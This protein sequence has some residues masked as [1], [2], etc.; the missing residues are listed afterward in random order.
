MRPSALPYVGILSSSKSPFR[1]PNL[2]V[3]PYTGS[4][5]LCT[6]SLT[7]SV[8]TSKDGASTQSKLGVS[9]V[10][11]PGNRVPTTIIEDS[12]A[13]STQPYHNPSKSSSKKKVHYSS[14]SN[15]RIERHGHRS[16]RDYGYDSSRRSSPARMS[17]LLE[18]ERD[19]E[20]YNLR[21]VR[22]ALD[23]A[24]GT[25]KQLTASFDHL[26]GLPAESNKEN[27]RLKRERN[28]ISNKLND[29]MEDLDHEKRLNRVLQQESSGSNTTERPSSR[30]A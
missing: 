22:E 6:R 19:D 11:I 9:S 15:S 4:N 12:K 10:S 27:R 28:D 5:K 17:D 26:N 23:A 30:P 14:S 24:N 13:S 21:A 7:S 1:A 20:H 8:P 3:H 18:N 25:I 29:L 2:D 16:S